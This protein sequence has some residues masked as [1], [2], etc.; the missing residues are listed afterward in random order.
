MKITS[1][2]YLK[3]KEKRNNSTNRFINNNNFSSRDSIKLNSKMRLS[4][5]NVELNLEEKKP[6]DLRCINCYLIPFLTLNSSSHSINL[7]CNF[8]H[9]STIGV[10]EYLKKGYDNNFNNLSCYKCKIKIL[11]NEKNFVYCKECS[12][13]LC[14]NCIK[15]HNKLYEDN[16]HMVNLDK[17]D[18][19]C[20]LHNETYDYY[21]SDCRKNICQYCLDEFHNDHNLIDLDDINLKRKE[22]KRIKEN[23]IKEKENYLNIPKIFNE[24]YEKLKV[25]IDN[26]I[27]N[28]KKEFK[29][30]ESIINTYENK[31]DNYN[32]IMNCKNLEFNIEPYTVD[33][34]ISI[35]EN[36]TKLM[37]YL[38]VE[39]AKLN[40]IN[41]NIDM[42]KSPETSKI[43]KDKAI[44][45]SKSNDARKSYKFNRVNS[46]DINN[47]INFIN[48]IGILNSQINKK[49]KDK[50]NIFNSFKNNYDKV[51]KKNFL[52]KKS[53][54]S[55]SIDRNIIYEEYSKKYLSKII[56][57][58]NSN[59]QTKNNN[60]YSNDIDN[61]NIDEG[62]LS[63][64]KININE[65]DEKDEKEE[66]DEKKGKKEKKEKDINNT[67]NN[68]IEKE[69]IIIK[70]NNNNSINTFIN[71]RN[72]FN[73][74]E[75]FLN[76][77]IISNSTNNM[78]SVKPDAKNL[79]MSIRLNKNNMLG[80]IYNKG[81]K[82]NKERY[83][84]P[85]IIKIVNNNTF[86]LNNKN[87]SY[88]N[89]EKKIIKDMKKINIKP[90]SKRI[91]A[92]YDIRYHDEDE[93]TNEE[94]E[95][96]EDEEEEEDEDDYAS[97]NLE[98]T[99]EI[100]EEEKFPKKNKNLGILKKD[101]NYQISER[102]LL[103]N[104][105][106]NEFEKNKEMISEE[107]EDSSYRHKKIYKKPSISSENNISEL[108]SNRNNN[109][110][111]SYYKD[112]DN[113]S[114][115]NINEKKANIKIIRDMNINE[116]RPKGSILKIKEADN[117]VCCMLEVRDNIFACGFLLGEIDI[118]DVNYLNC[119]FTIYE[120]KTR[121]TNMVLLKDKSLL[122]T[123]FDYTM[124][125]I[126]ITNNNSYLVDYTFN[127][128][129]N[130]VYKGIELTN[131]NIVSISFKGNI[132]IF[133][134]TEKNNN[135][136]N[137]ISHEIADEEIFNVIELF[138]NKQIV[139][140]T[141]EC[142]RFFSI[143]NF[144]N[145][146][147][148]H[149]LEFV[150][151]N[152]LIQFNKNTL[153]ALLRHEIGLININQRQCISKLSLG[154]VGKPECFCYLKDNTILV[155]ISNN[156]KENNVIEFIFRQIGIKM[157]KMKLMSEKMDLIDKKKKD[158]YCRITSLIELKN[159][160]IAYGLAGFEDSK[161][162]GNISI[163]D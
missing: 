65:K 40:N 79:K 124:K 103:S 73:S 119:L 143:D 12:E 108:L 115:R 63:F 35:F 117:T 161:L 110:D 78:Y 113:S 151:G 27:N 4:D 109:K 130:V 18:T 37:N 59:Y 72:I 94:E 29:F 133:K 7:D 137:F 93:E 140:S 102:R 153:L 39:G 147:N 1:S 53:N 9:S 92:K 62:D 71:K 28:I 84:Q 146:G 111:S 141:D 155:G 88:I 36:F 159:N 11:R 86:D 5:P 26:I 33:N 6:K 105:L 145:I 152:N 56:E 17:F 90:N 21:C 24:L 43:N 13:L 54:Y 138:P 112:K 89:R 131:G 70:K 69:K 158:D 162:V 121:V 66:K 68:N 81:K 107:N 3:S 139:F 30:K 77:K 149:S 125:K 10:E 76:N 91:K 60:S 46:A 55:N 22:I 41:K 98:E 106:K 16:H 67:F 160:V 25:E 129:K 52:I 83:S 104:E 80:E 120:H 118:Y 42:L 123:S 20:I 49:D 23:F 163:I 31:I 75:M 2:E 148:I 51:Y 132:N 58:D 95:D 100:E 38:N 47:N 114:E 61:N 122:S 154:N 44:F 144:Q 48:E 74:N 97:E 116:F 136:L 126:R 96:E 57:D 134:K 45:F 14:K 135:Y 127:I 50:D 34:N 142:L 156:Q 87:N 101:K 64:P 99:E 157:N 32:A 19:T 128:F 150:K 8:G 15:K 85:D 82:Q